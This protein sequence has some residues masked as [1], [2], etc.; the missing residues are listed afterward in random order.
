[1]G[2]DD[3]KAMG[4]A[5]KQMRAEK[6]NITYYNFLKAKELIMKYDIKYSFIDE[7]YFI[8]IN[9]DNKDYKFDTAYNRVFY[10]DKNT[11]LTLLKFLKAN[12]ISKKEDLRD[13]S[14]YNTFTIGKYTGYTIEHVFNTNPQYLAWAYLKMNLESNLKNNIKVLLNNNK[15]DVRC[16]LDVY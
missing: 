3:S 10:K 6:A 8:K 4:L 16:L 11:N 2:R 1:M 14:E 5:G 7:R 9:I 12:N 15:N 13:P